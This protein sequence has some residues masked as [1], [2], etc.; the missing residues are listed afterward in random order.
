MR[1]DSTPTYPQYEDP[2]KQEAAR[3]LASGM[4]PTPLLRGMKTVKRIDAWLKVIERFEGADVDAFAEDLREK[5][6]AINDSVETAFQRASTLEGTVDGEAETAVADGGAE[7]GA[8]ETAAHS[9]TRQI[10]DDQERK[11]Y[12]DRAAFESMKT[13]WRP[14]VFSEKYGSVEA[15]KGALEEELQRNTIRP[16][17]VELLE[18]RLAELGGENDE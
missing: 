7:L 17:I 8:A 2:N 14:F 13:D 6:A 3:F 18:E 1:A 10:G 11:T 12:R 15:V 9:V 5:R 16:H 4:D